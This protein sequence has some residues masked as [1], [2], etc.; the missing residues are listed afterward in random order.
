LVVEEVRGIALEVGG[1][2]AMLPK[3]DA[4]EETAEGA[5][6]MRIWRGWRWT[7]LTCFSAA[8][9][10]ERAKGAAREH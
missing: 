6:T 4:G 1:V 2:E 7:P 5:A 10:A 3:G 8:M 9:I